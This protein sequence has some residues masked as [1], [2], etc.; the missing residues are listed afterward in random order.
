LRAPGSDWLFVKLYAPRIFEDDMLTGPMAELC[1]Q[2]LAI[3]AADDWFFI[4]Y[5]DPDPHIRLRFHGQPE[6]LTGELL[7]MVCRWANGILSDEL[8]VR[9]CFDTYDREIERFGGTAGTAAA[10]TIFGADSRAVIEMLRLLRVGLLDMDMTS[11]AVLSVDDLL[12]GLGSGEASLVWYR[13]KVAPRKA[14]GEEYRR[15]KTNLRRLLG[16]PEHLRSQPGGDALARLLATRRDDLAIVSAKLDALAAAK[17]LFQPR[18]AVVRTCVHLHCNRLLG[19]NQST[20]D[21]ILELLGRTRHALD[22]A[23]LSRTL[24]GPT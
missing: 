2:A 10:E 24:D 9:L 11:L 16:D 20:E 5:A 17:Q 3:G 8:G 7:P 18:S 12:A 19:A 21:Q 14:A 23:P 15:R 6:R 22:Q 4:R 13:E 1:Q